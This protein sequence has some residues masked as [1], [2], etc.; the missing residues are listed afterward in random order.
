MKKIYSKAI[1]AAF[2]AVIAAVG[3]SC[4]SDEEA[5]VPE[6]DGKGLTEISLVVPPPV[7][8]E[9]SRTT[10]NPTDKIKW[11]TNDKAKM[12]L[13]RSATT[14]KILQSSAM[15]ILKEDGKTAKFTYVAS[16]YPAT[17]F[18]KAFYPITITTDNS[19]YPPKTEI[20]GSPS[21]LPLGIAIEQVQAEAG[22]TTFGSASVPM[23]SD[24]LSDSAAN[25]VEVTDKQAVIQTKMR[26]LSWI[27]AFYIYDSNGAYSTESV[28]K[29]SLLS[30]TGYVAGITMIDSTVADL[31]QLTGSSQLVNVTLSNPFALSGV[32]SK[33]QSAPIY[34]SIIPGGFAGKIVVETD[35]A[36]YTFQF[37]TPKNFTRAEVKDMLLNL[38]N[39]QAVR[40]AKSEVTTP[41]ITVTSMNRKYVA[42]NRTQ[43]TLTIKK[44]N[45][46][47]PS[48]F[49]VY[50][51]AQKTVSQL[52][53]SEVVQNG[54]LY[55][56]GD[57]DSESFELQLD[58][59]VTYKKEVSFTTGTFAFGV[60]PFDQ[61]G[62]I[63]Q[64][65]GDNSW[66]HATSANPNRNNTFK[67][68][69]LIH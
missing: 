49:Y 20:I 29:V 41:A 64:V 46:T 23:I 17:A 5:S 56:F 52:T 30:N 63:G 36:Y 15:E 47:D 60:V 11:N 10:L 40:S 6:P 16:S 43:V 62:N 19:S 65:K 39:V 18:Y 35:Q 61:Y 45:G 44:Y 38:S 69:D 37:D 12:G 28:Q 1:M 57:S 54:D 8:D 2:V 26:I 66:G 68:S 4:S 31:P 27:V 21:S 14:E 48:G 58:G 55:T 42:S 22:E 3:A 67:D 9:G 32:T 24:L 50:C 34:L 13:S 25:D 33:E 51:V 59:S 7:A 53:S